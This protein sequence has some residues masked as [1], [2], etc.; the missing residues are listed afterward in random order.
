MVVTLEHPEFVKLQQQCLE[1]S[2][3]LTFL[4]AEYK[5]QQALLEAQ[6]SS[7]KNFLKAESDYN[8]AM[9]T[10]NGQ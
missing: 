9:A 3:Q 7:R 8:T 2:G 10:Y 6:V 5:R 1:I 4:K